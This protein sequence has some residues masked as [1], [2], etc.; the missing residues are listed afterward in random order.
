METKNEILSQQNDIIE[1]LKHQLEIGFIKNE[2]SK[3]LNCKL[4]FKVKEFEQEMA[5][6]EQENNILKNEFEKVVSELNGQIEQLNNN[7]GNLKN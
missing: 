7:I 1:D 3:G 4:N 5:C 6:L 2:E